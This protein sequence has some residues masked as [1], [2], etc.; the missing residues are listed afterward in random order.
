M[1]GWLHIQINTIVFQ[2]GIKTSQNIRK[3][4]LRFPRDTALPCVNASLYDLA[5]F[6]GRLDTSNITLANIHLGNKDLRKI[7]YT[8]NFSGKILLTLCEIE[9]FRMKAMNFI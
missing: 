8:I 9:I 6:I 5:K 1:S 7:C 4:V 3:S 2:K